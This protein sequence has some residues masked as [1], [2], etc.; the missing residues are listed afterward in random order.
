[1]I[2]QTFTLSAARSSRSALFGAEASPAS[3]ASAASLST[4]NS[5]PLGAP[6][7]SCSSRPPKLGGL[8]R[9]ED[10]RHRARGRQRVFA[11]MRLRE[12]GSVLFHPSGSTC[13]AAR[14]GC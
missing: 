13:G 12:V 14:S 9:T 1:M 8:M 6:P 3:I 7:M 2:G 11:G 5:R 10:Q 4:V